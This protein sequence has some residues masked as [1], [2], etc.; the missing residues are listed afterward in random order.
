MQSWR[1]ENLSLSRPLSALSV[2]NRRRNPSYLTRRTTVYTL[3]MCGSSGILL[4]RRRT[5]ARTG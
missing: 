3:L 2:V 5:D 4:R 1:S